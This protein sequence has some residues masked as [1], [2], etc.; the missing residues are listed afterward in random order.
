M[1]EALRKL[2]VLA[3]I[4]NLEKISLARTD[5]KI[6]IDG[7]ITENI[8]GNKSVRQWEL[9]SMVVCNFIL[10]AILREIYVETME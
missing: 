5:K 9:L 4:M 3:K 6:R 8:T 2:D 10:E 1:Y 7:Q